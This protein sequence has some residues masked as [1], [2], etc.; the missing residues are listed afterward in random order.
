LIKVLFLTS[1]ELRYKASRN[2]VHTEFVIT[3][4]GIFPLPGR[5]RDVY[6]VCG[7]RW[8]LDQPSLNTIAV[9]GTLLDI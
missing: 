1:Y 8:S 2:W 7:M 3:F 9:T 4:L 6:S 5:T